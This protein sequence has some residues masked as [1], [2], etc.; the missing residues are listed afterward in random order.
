MIL[1]FDQPSFSLGL[2]QEKDALPSREHDQ[3]GENNTHHGLE[4][5]L[6]TFL[7]RKASVSRQSHSIYLAVTSAGVAYLIV[8]E[9]VNFVGVAIMICRLFVTSM[10]DCPHYLRNLG[11]FH[12]IHQKYFIYFDMWIGRII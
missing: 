10:L 5:H 9:K 6:D 7:S 8:L 4:T 12:F 3:M 1:Q 2:T 11:K